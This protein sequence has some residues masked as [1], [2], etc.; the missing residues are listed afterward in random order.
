MTN[1]QTSPTITSRGYSAVLADMPMTSVVALAQRGFNH[2]MGNEVASKVKTYKDNTENDQSDAAIE[3]FAKA[4][5]DEFMAKIMAGT[6]GIR[7]VGAAVDPV[8][9]EMEKLASA[10]ITEQLKANGIKWQRDRD[11]S[12]KVVKGSEAFVALS[13]GKFTRDELIERRLAKHG[14]RLRETAEKNIKARE[15]KLAKVRE[16]GVDL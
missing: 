15:R 16:A 11:A 5:R 3:T 6:L 13:D 12:G 8:E 4:K 1:E 2:V 9:A 14:D 10:E 7:T